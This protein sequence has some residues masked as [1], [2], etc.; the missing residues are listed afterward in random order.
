MEVGYHQ[1][2]T[3]T[4]SACLS[5]K[6]IAAFI[7]FSG[8]NRAVNAALTFLNGYEISSIAVNSSYLTPY[9]VQVTLSS[10]TSQGL[11]VMVSSTSATQVHSLFVSYIA[12]SSTILNLVAGNYVYNKYTPTMSLL[13][14]TTTDISNNNIGFHGFNSFIVRN[15]RS[16]FSLNALVSGS[17]FSFSSAS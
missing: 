17:R 4:L 14:S 5:G 1:I 16:S 7:P 3:G 11:S 9:E 12:Y 6:D 13:F 2:D 15:T 8:P 10:V